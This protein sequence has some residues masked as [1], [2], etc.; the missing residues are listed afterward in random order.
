MDRPGSALTLQIIST[1]MNKSSFYWNW[2]ASIAKLSHTQRNGTM[3]STTS[4]SPIKEKAVIAAFLAV[5]TA[6]TSLPNDAEAASQSLAPPPTYELYGTDYKW[7]YRFEVTGYSLIPGIPD[8]GAWDLAEYERHRTYKPG[9]RGREEGVAYLRRI[10]PKYWRE[11]YKQ[12]YYV[13]E[14]KWFVPD[15]D[16]QTPEYENLNHHISGQEGGNFLSGTNDPPVIDLKSKR[17]LVGRKTTYTGLDWFGHPTSGSGKTLEIWRT[18]MKLTAQHTSGG[19][20]RFTVTVNYGVNGSYSPTSVSRSV[21][22]SPGE[23]TTMSLR[24]PS[25]GYAVILSV[26]IR[27]NA[28]P[29]VPPTPNNGGGNGGSGG[30]V[31]NVPIIPPG[32]PS[33][34]YEI[35]LRPDSNTQST[36]Q[37]Q[38]QSGNG[39]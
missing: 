21:T 7:K 15:N 28:P 20:K 1:D 8:V 11:N 26:D 35:P 18:R 22:L 17:S 2:L 37:A 13:K 4:K 36:N 39:N 25:G 38:R 24:A 30:P 31:F 34:D 29:V 16:P 32:P 12:N 9:S 33:L 19:A 23:T 5:V 10:F 6:L 27:E 14:T 3:E